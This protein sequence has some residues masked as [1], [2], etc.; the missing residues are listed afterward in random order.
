MAVNLLRSSWPLAIV[1]ALAALGCE[2]SSNSGGG[3]SL[4]DMAGAME[5]KKTAKV[6][7]EKDEKEAAERDAQQA[8]S[9]PAASAI[10][11]QSEANATPEQPRTVA[12]R[13]GVGEGG[14]YT[15]IVGARRHVLN[16]VED[17]AWLQA[18]QHF[19]ATNGRLPKD[20][21]EFM[22]QVVK[23]LEINLGYK[24]ENQEF[25]YDPSV[26][27]WGEVYVVEKI[28]EEPAQK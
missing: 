10:N 18:V 9:P 19:Q 11:D 20:N 7:Q 4:D 3:A 14:Y 6:Q 21:A 22:S 16:K 1:V 26:G 27:E 17:L 12:G 24:E 8:A 23:P 2:S 25:I 15:A 5:A 13:S 28:E